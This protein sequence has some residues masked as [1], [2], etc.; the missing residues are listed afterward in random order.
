M[1]NLSE[2]CF[3]EAKM[4]FWM[5]DLQF[6][7]ACGAFGVSFSKKDHTRKI[8]IVTLSE[9]LKNEVFRAPQAKNLEK[10]IPIARVF[11]LESHD[12]MRSTQ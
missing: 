6:F 2:T 8:Q 4:C 1:K 11:A 5:V 9:T 3:L 12:S 10:S 7:F